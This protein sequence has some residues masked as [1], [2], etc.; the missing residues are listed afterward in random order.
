[1][2]RVIDSTKVNGCNVFMKVHYNS[3]Q[4]WV[5]RVLVY[6][7]NNIDHARGVYNSIVISYNDVKWRWYERTQ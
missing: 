2:E 6:S 5:D 7:S 3:F 4:V 1:M